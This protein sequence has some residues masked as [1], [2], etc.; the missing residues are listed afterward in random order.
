M[1]ETL[2]SVSVVSRKL[3]FVLLLMTCTLVAYKLP[4]TRITWAYETA[5]E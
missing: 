5:E 2:T 3:G 1:V 4:E